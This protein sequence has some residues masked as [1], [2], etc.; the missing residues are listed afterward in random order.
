MEAVTVSRRREEGRKPQLLLLETKA[1][2]AGSDQVKR[3]AI[4]AGS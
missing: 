3:S 4:Q 2:P 1:G